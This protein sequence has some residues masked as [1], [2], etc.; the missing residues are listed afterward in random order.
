MSLLS[1]CM[2]GVPPTGHGDALLPETRLCL[3]ATVL[4]ACD[5]AQGAFDFATQPPV[6]SHVGTSFELRVVDH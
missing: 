4:Q 5:Q 6:V 1:V 2:F 3:V